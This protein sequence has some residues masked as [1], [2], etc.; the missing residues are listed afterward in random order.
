MFP[1][2]TSNDS[3]LLVRQALS[4]TAILVKTTVLCKFKKYE[5]QNHE[6]F[7]TVSQNSKLLGPS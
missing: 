1:K 2:I 7:L 3:T 4:N 6:F 5:K